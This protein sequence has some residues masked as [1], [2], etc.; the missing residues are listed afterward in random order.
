MR[1]LRICVIAS[2]RFPVA[3]PFAG[4]LEAHTHALAGELRAPGPP[5]RPS[6]PRPGS[7][8]ALG[9]LELA[10]LPFTSSPAARADVAAPP[11]WWMR[12]HHA[13]LGLMLAPAA[14]A[15]PAGFDLVHNNSLHHL[16]VAMAGSLDVPVVTTLHTPPLP[17]LES[18]VA[19][20]R[21]RAARFIAVSE[22]MRRQWERSV[23]AEVVHNG[24]D[25][26]RWPAGPGRL[27]RGVVGPAG[28]REGTPRRHRR[29]ARAAGRPRPR[30]ARSLRPR[31]LRRQEVA[32]AAA[33]ATRATWATSTSGR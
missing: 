30:R 33:A 24:V 13:Y 22:A 16:P 10:V 7:D 12:E 8:P 9:A 18:A 11:E 5:G 4:G 3:E 25:T 28:A 31:L 1:P 21:R 29:A 26:R 6:S 27:A 15:H 20:R 32:P 19:L 17:W 14:G 2:S 23:D